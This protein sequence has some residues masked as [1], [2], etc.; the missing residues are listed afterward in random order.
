MTNDH[1]QCGGLDFITKDGYEMIQ[2]VEKSQ[3]PV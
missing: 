1:L 2:N 3:I